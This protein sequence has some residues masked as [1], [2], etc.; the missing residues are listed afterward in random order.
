MRKEEGGNMIQYQ[1]GVEVFI[2]I[3]FCTADKKQRDID[4]VD[5]CP[6]GHETCSGECWA[7]SEDPEDRNP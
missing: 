5:E 4:D 7:Y 1:D 2:C 6:L 3:G